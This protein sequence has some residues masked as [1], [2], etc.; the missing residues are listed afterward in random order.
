MNYGNKTGLYFR[1][2]L[3]SYGMHEESSPIRAHNGRG[4]PVRDAQLLR[5]VT[6]TTA[7]SGDGGAT[8]LYIGTEAMRGLISIA[9]Q[10]AVLFRGSASVR[11]F[12]R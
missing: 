5:P 8:T 10:P 9:E 4:K 2:D 7:R 6:A 11:G 12:H 1:Y 3:L